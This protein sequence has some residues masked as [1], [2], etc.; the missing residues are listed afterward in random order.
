MTN[1][2]AKLNGAGNAKWHKSN[3]KQI[4]TN[5]KYIGDDLL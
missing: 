1:N 5:E 4:L 3:I 2:A